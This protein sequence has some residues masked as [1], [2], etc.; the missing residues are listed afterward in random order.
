MDVHTGGHH[1]AVLCFAS[2]PTEVNYA[3]FTVCSFISCHHITSLIVFLSG[4]NGSIQHQQLV[5]QHL[6][7]SYDTA[8]R[9]QSE[10]L[11]IYR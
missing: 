7:G 11:N 2:L 10:C 1:V 4:L 6:N 9:R 5:T 8:N 3:T